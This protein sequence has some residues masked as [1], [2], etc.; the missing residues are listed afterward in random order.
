[1][2]YPDNGRYKY[3]RNIPRCKCGREIQHPKQPCE[4]CG[5]LLCDVCEAE[6]MAQQRIEL[7]EDGLNVLDDLEATP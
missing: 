4:C 1:M 3:D 5:N 6:H 2:S 7:T